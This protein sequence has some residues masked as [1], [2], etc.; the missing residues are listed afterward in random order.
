MLLG[1]ANTYGGVTD[2]LAG[3]ARRRQP[4][5]G[6]AD[7]NTVVHQDAALELTSSL[8]GEPL[9]LHGQGILPLQKN[10]HTGA[11]RSVANNNVYTGTATLVADTETQR[12]VVQAP[13]PAT[14]TFR[15]SFISGATTQ[16]T[17]PLAVNSTAS[18]VQTALNNLSLLNGKVSVVQNGPGDFTVT[19][20]NGLAN[21]NVN[22]LVLLPNGATT[23]SVTTLLD[24]NTTVTIGVDSDTLTIGTDTTGTLTGTG[25]IVSAGVDLEKELTGKLVLNT[26]NAAFDG[27]ANVNQGVLRVCRIPW[28]WAPRPRAPT[29]TTAPSCRCRT[30]TTMARRSRS[31][32]SAAPDRFQPPGRGVGRNPQHRRQQR[33]AGAGHPGLRVE[34]GHRAVAL[35]HLRHVA[36]STLTIDGVVSQD[37]T[38]VSRVSTDSNLGVVKAGL[39]T[40]VFTKDNSYTG[41]TDVQ[42]GT[43]NVQD[44]GGAGQQL[45]GAQ[46][47]GA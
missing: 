34:D 7:G 16:T 46:R 30:R 25:G 39:G 33:L 13:N 20:I 9:E 4:R 15:L 27:V 11:L 2:V 36:N 40:I 42:Q 28:L 23:G 45:V 35:G 24:G 31:P 26:A 41:L 18:Q 21:V 3:R 12:I 1:S 5:P 47:P 43:L 38:D 17:V 37:T 10:N 8:Q 19:F 29:S 14:D 6:P 32:A 44:G 22:Q